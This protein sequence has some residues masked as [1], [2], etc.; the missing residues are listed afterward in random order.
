MTSEQL[1]SLSR[2]GYPAAE[3]ALIEKILPAI[4]ITAR[5]IRKRYSGIM[6]DTDDLVQEALLGFLRA[7][8]TYDPMTGNLFLTYMQAIAENAMMD[9]VRKSV[10][11]IPF[12]GM[13]ISLDA[14]LPGS[15]PADEVTYGDIILNDYS[16]TPEQI[17]IK[18]ET[19]TEVR[20]ALKKISER[21]QAYLHYRYGFEDDLQHDL[22]ETAAHFH[23]S[24]SR[25]KGLEKTALENVRLKLP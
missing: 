22:S 15:D 19:I 9:Y 21:E 4:R 14:P 2:A 11:A 6:L 13:I 3:N 20:N 23:L 1:W 10:S 17:F 12:S 8:E 24:T 18:K 5:K 7:V 16:R 25:A